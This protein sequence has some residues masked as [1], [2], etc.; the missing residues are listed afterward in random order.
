MCDAI[1]VNPPVNL[2][3]KFQ[4]G[5]WR[6]LFKPYNHVECIKEVSV[7]TK[8]STTVKQLNSY[9]KQGHR[10]ASANKSM[11]SLRKK[12]P[13]RL[14]N[15]K[16]QKYL[17]QIM[18]MGYH[19]SRAADRITLAK[20]LG[21][22]EKSVCRGYLQDLLK[23]N[24]AIQKLYSVLKDR[25]QDNAPELYRIRNLPAEFNP[26]DFISS[27]AELNLQQTFDKNSELILYSVLPILSQL[28]LLCGNRVI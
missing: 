16:V 7:W 23:G 22:T 6:T 20:E 25:V 10:E 18:N 2:N 5:P 24:R 4:T 27:K 9:H 28:L 3:F 26:R 17:D 15:Q 11:P 21:K 1:P 8:R 13:S 12:T 19:Q 14:S